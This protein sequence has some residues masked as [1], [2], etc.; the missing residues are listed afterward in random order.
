MI[1]SFAVELIFFTKSHSR[2][3]KKTSFRSAVVSLFDILSIIYYNRFKY[4]K[5]FNML[6]CGFSANL[7]CYVNQYLTLWNR[8]PKISQMFKL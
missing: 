7:G 8:I 6:R 4:E 2:T 3:D 5:S 1:E